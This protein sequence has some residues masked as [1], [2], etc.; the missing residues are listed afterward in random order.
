MGGHHWF[1]RGRIDADGRAMLLQ[2]TS[3]YVLTMKLK[4][5]ILTTLLLSSAVQLNAAEP[6]RPISIEAYGT[7]GSYAGSVERNNLTSETVAIDYTMETFGASAAIRNWDL[8]RITSLGDLDGTDTNV[9]LYTRKKV[10]NEGYWGVTAAAT[11]LSNNDN[12]TDQTFAPYGAVA[13][14]TAD[15]GNYFDVGYASIGFEDTTNNQFTATWGVALFNRYVWAQTRLYY[16]NLSNTVQDV[17]QT[18]AL[19]E[20]LTWY[21]VPHTFSL[22]FYGLVGQRIYGYD[23]DTRI[24]YSLSDVQQGSA[25]LTANWE[26]TPS[27]GLFADV[28]YEAYEKQTINDNYSATYGTVGLKYKF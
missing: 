15:G 19:E 5:T 20:R 23:P 26:L 28:A 9:L 13:Y 1:T 6:P 8:S 21:V 11:Y 18:I 3:R 17:S 25:G 4:S 7:Y 16:G 22:T 14:K 24:V 10:G 12:N 27:L 2:E